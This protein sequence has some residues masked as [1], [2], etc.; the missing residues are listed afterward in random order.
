MNESAYPDGLDCVWFASDREGYLGAFI[1]AG[2]GPVPAEVLRSGS[3]PVEDI[4]ER[5]CELPNVSDAL[6]LV[7]DERPDDFVD[8]AERG[9]Y[10]YDWTDINRTATKAVRLYEPVA[11]PTKPISV[12]AL[13]DDLAALPR[14]LKFADVSFAARTPIDVHEYEACR[15]GGS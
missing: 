7:S 12:D 9:V 11:V 6:L 4:E 5:I 3:M 2:V 13:P 15:E 1:T 10:V 8:L 14:A